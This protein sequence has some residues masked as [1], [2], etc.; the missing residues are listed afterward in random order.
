MCF[1]RSVFL[2]FTKLLVSPEERGTC[3]ALGG[4]WWGEE[5]I[6][7]EAARTGRVWGQRRG[8]GGKGTGFTLLAGDTSWRNINAN[9][10]LKSARLCSPSHR[11]T[12]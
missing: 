9:T 8:E 11:N 1:S 3:S 4:V 10:S 7:E 12:N 2:D 5:G 6:G